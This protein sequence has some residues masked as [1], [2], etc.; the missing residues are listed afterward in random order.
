MFI[1]F[2]M[3]VAVQTS[4]HTDLQM[5]QGVRDIVT[6]HVTPGHTLIVSYNTPAHTL[7]GS[8][9]APAHALCFSAGQNTKRKGCLRCVSDLPS[10]E[11][12]AQLILEE[13][14]KI[15]AWS[16]LSFDAT[17]DCKEMLPSSSKYE[18]YAL[19]SLRQD[20]GDV[21]KDIRHQVKKLRN[22][23]E[24]NPRAKFVILVAEIRHVNA[25]LFAE[26]ISAELWTLRVVNSVVLI[27]TLDTHLATG[28]ANTLDSYIYFPYRPTVQCP[29]VKDVVLQ[30]RWILDSRNRSHFIHNT[31]LFSQEIPNDLHG[32]PFTVSTFLVP[33]LIM[34]K[35]IIEVDPE[36]VIYDKGVRDT[37]PDR[38]CEEYQQFPKIP[39]NSTWPSRLGQ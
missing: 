14:N 37:D 10:T 8:R 16:L 35:N 23:W 7:Q 5:V 6:R 22:N 9:K 30:D 31:S 13:F 21:V 32:C 38:T 27:P 11:D 1:I 12:M 26:D 34:R 25:K 39:E 4:G 20:H 19:L 17:H 15:E 3:C 24:W 28:T 2:I 29:Q 18:G 33:P 36:N